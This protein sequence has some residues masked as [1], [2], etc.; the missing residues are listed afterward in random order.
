MMQAFVM[1]EFRARYLLTYALYL[2]VETLKREE[3]PAWNDINDMEEML[4]QDPELA[5]LFRES[6][7]LKTARKLGWVMPSG[8]L[9]EEIIREA[10]EWIEWHN[11]IVQLFPK[12]ESP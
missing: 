4:N 7:V 2:A 11:N 9:T 6:H 10:R 1:D 8:P 3:D 12:P 5:R